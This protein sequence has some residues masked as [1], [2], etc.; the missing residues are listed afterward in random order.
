[1][2]KSLGTGAN[3]Q[4][5][6]AVRRLLE[7]E[8]GGSQSRAAKAFGVTQGYISDFLDG[9][10]GAGAKLLRGVAP[11]DESVAEILGVTSNSDVRYSNREL[12]IRLVTA[13]SGAPEADVTAAADAAGTDLSSDSDLSVV[14]WV[15]AIREWMR[16]LRLERR[17]VGESPVSP[18]EL[19]ASAD[20]V[21]LNFQRALKKKR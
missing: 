11:F 5:R 17:R 20:D 1:M 21:R 13:D 19:D 3:E 9:K 6:A 7:T 14:A 10:R 16:A 15:D 12:A 4:L 18:S 2:S 8:F